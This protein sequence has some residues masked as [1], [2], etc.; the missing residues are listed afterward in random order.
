MMS[1]SRKERTGKSMKLGITG[2]GMIVQDLMPA[3]KDIGIEKTWIQ[4]TPR[5]EEKAKAM[6]STYGLDGYVLDYDE[7][8]KQDIDTVYVALPNHLHYAFA[9]EA[10]QAGKHVMIEKPVCANV[11]ELQ[12]LLDE[13]AKAGVYIYEAMTIHDTPVYKG[14]KQ[15]LGKVGDVKIVSFN[16]S[17]Y[18]SRYDAFKRGEILPAF[19][20]HK[21]GG[22]LYDINVYNIHGVVGL[23][24]KPLSVHYEANIEKGI[25]T[26]G[27]LTMDYGTF[28]AVCIGAKDCQAPVS[29]NIQGDEGVLNMTRP[30]SRMHEFSYITNKGDS[31]TFSYESDT[32][33]MVY[34]FKEFMRIIDNHDDQAARAHNDISMTCAQIMQD[35][36]TQKGIVFDND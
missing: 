25:D 16:Y 5:S 13:A 11:K 9:L 23:F 36:R 26:S 35:A 34:E 29:L 14:L 18:S 17:Q 20:Y 31:E 28:K 22:A 21:A 32:H 10:I 33:R 2:T 27:I 30:L 8:L 19:D 1:V 15:S 24:G 6:V 12:S 7:L 4:A 3:Y